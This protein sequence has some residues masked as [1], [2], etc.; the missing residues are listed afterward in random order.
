[1]AVWGGLI[2]SYEKK[3]SERQ[4]R[5]G[6]IYSFEYIV[7][8]NSNKRKENLPQGTMQINRGKQQNGKH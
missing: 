4:R 1:M 6:K 3:R 7:P 8:R 2:N 5:K